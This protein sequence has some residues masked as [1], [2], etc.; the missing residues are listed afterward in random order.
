MNKQSSRGDDVASLG[1]QRNVTITVAGVGER[2]TVL[3]HQVVLGRGVVVLHQEAQH[4]QLRHV[5]LE[6]EALVPH[7]VEAIVFNV[8]GL[9]AGVVGC[10]ATHLHPDQWVNDGLVLLLVH[11]GQLLR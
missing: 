1:E 4:G 7:G 6:L 10:H 9:L 2:E 3:A 8:M 11:F 5:H